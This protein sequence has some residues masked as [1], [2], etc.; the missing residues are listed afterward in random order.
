MRG[1][2]VERVLAAS[3]LAVIFT[4]S[5][6]LSALAWTTEDNAAPAAIQAPAPADPVAPTAT[7]IATSPGRSGLTAPELE[8]RV[9]QPESADLPP[10]SASDI[11]GPPTAATDIK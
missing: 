4:T 8:A 11:T 7:G 1:V 10:P 5:S 9:P 3:A 6:S 2:W